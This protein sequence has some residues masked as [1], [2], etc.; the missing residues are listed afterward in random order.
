MLILRLEIS[1]G[2]VGIKVEKL[3]TWYGIWANCM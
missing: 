1:L 2:E 3:E